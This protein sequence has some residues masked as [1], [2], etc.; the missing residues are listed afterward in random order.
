M[1]DKTTIIPSELSKLLAI[2]Q[3]ERPTI[4]TPKIIEEGKEIVRPDA[5]QAIVQL[6][7]LGQMTKIR[8]A[9]KKQEFQGEVDPRTLDATDEIQFI[10]LIDRYP[11]VPWISA[12]LINDGPDVA[13]IA[14]NR[15]YD[16]FEMGVNET[17]TI[18]RAH[19]EERIRVIYYICDPGETASIRVM[20]EY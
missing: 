8:K 19:A 3:L 4:V 10:S 9:L 15:P 1:E 7:Q 17:R 12:F 16:Q 20:G 6:A 2:P 18:S 5:L 11:N 14:I 13:K